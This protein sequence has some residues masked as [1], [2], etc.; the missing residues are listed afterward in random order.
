MLASALHGSP[1]V[2]HNCNIWLSVTLSVRILVFLCVVLHILLPWHLESVSCLSET[3]FLSV[4]GDFMQRY[5][6][7]RQVFT[8]RQIKVS[9][10]RRWEFLINSQKIIM[11]WAMHEE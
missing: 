8:N 6:C 4:E 3:I 1:H 11:Q 7:S 10:K 5:P 2:P 9:Q